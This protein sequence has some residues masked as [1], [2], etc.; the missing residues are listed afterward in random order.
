MTKFLLHILGNGIGIYVAARFIQGVAWTG[1][2]ISLLLAGL[3]LGLLNVIVK[4]ILKILSAPLILLTL[5]L[6]IIIINFFI[7]WMLQ[8]ISPELVLQG[9]WAYFWTLAILTGVNYIISL[10]GEKE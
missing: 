10:L 6:F 8:R 2:I 1:D 9:F 4:P 3:I 7:L 5:G